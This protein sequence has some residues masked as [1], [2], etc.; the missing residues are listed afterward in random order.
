MSNAIGESLSRIFE[1]QGASV[2]RANYQG[3]IGPHV[4]KAMYGIMKKDGGIL[5]TTPSEKANYIGECYAFGSDLYDTDE[6]AKKEINELNQKLYAYDPLYKALYDEGREVTLEAF[7]E[8]YKMLGTK[9][10]VYFFES[11][12]VDSGVALVKKYTDVFEASEGAMVFKAEKYN[13]KLHTRVFITK[14]GLPTYEAKELALTQKKFETY[15]PDISVVTTAVEQKDYV[16]V[17]TEAIRHMFPNEQY[18]ERME[19]IAHGMM[20]FATGKMSS[21]KGNVITGESLIRDAKSAIYEKMADRV[22]ENK[23]AIAEA[24]GVAAIKYSILRSSTGSDII[25]DFETSISFEGDSGPY[26][27]Y[28]AT[29]ANAVLQKADEADINP[30]LS[31]KVPTGLIERLLERFPVIVRRASDEREPHHLVTY[32]T[33]L[34]GAFNSFYGNETIV[35]E[36]EEVSGDRVALTKAVLLVLAR[37]LH[38]LGIRLPEKM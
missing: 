4:A 11:E 26:V 10:D 1:S 16:A 38:L 34:A 5:G 7:E 21:R 18:T 6:T 3:D 29:R 37:G 30:S 31:D 36:D 2:I 19:H 13:P 28:T 12:M 25:Y 24:V 9:F 8:I 17:V 14:Y 33:E 35:S 32:I 23:E 15:N 27:Q 22:Y 20:R